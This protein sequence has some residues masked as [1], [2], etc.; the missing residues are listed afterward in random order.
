[1]ALPAPNMRLLL[2]LFSFSFLLLPGGSRCWFPPLQQRRGFG[3]HKSRLG[4]HRSRL[5]FHGSRLGFH[6]S[7]LGLHRSRLGFHRRGLG[8]YKSG[9]GLYGSGCGNLSL[10]GG[11]KRPYTY[12]YTLSG[13]ISVFLEHLRPREQ[14]MTHLEL[15]LFSCV[16][17]THILPT[18]AGTSD[19][20]GG[21]KGGL[22]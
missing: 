10:E 3:F 14:E 6:G 16:C 4:F 5:G 20:G 21:G 15:L 19:P 1:M 7:R 9:L 22:G 2:L 11:I 12:S 13:S 17:R 18:A 8:F